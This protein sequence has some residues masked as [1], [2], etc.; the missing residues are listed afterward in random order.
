[1]MT[2]LIHFN[3]DNVIEKNF[4]KERFYQRVIQAGFK[5]IDLVVYDIWS[6]LK[7]T[8]TQQNLDL[9]INDLKPFYKIQP[10][11]ITKI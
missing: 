9:L 7:V 8:G 2:I 10:N 3:K 11:T 4:D 1:M 6:V 5:A